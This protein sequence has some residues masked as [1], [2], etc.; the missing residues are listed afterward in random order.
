MK[1]WNIV[2]ITCG[3]IATAFLVACGDST[4][5]YQIE[6]QH[7]GF[8]LSTGGTTESGSGLVQQSAPEGD[9]GLWELVE[10]GDD[11]YQIRSKQS[12]LYISAIDGQNAALE[13]IAEPGENALWEKVELDGDNAGYIQFTTNGTAQAQSINTAGSTAEDGAIRSAHTGLGAGS[14]WKLVEVE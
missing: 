6:N 2:K 13:Q 11:V 5:Y 12:Q 10:A 1:V 8:Y 9:N 14:Y 7:S 4:T 3:L